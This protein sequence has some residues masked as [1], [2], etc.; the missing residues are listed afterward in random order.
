MFAQFGTV[1]TCI[2]N[3]EKRHGFIKMISRADALAAKDGME[4]Y[5]P[6]D[7]Q[8]RVS[9]ENSDPHLLLPCPCA[10]H[11]RHAGVLALGLATVAT[12]KPASVSFPS[13]D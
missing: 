1:Q 11:L 12:I 13:G 7:M 2:V 4:N 10:D 8:L 9:S 5:R 3:Q 6:P